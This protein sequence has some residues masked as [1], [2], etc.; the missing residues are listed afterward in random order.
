MILI[1]I[2]LTQVYEFYGSNLW[3]TWGCVPKRN[4]ISVKKQQASV[5]LDDNYLSRGQREIK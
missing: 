4:S 3:I 1:H 2:K 5:I